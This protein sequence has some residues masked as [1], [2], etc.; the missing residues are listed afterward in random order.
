MFQL[1]I[2]EIPY[3]ILTDCPLLMLLILPICCCCVACKRKKKKKLTDIEDLQKRKI[4]G[5]V[6]AS[7]A[8]T[9]VTLLF[10]LV[11]RVALKTQ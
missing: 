3:F 4:R 10:M 2:Y 7:I 1:L 8:F 6:G 5:F 11:F 9:V